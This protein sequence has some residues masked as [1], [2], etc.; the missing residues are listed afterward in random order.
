MSDWV[1]GIGVL[2]G[3]LLVALLV[4]PW[5]ST[6]LDRFGHPITWYVEYYKWVRRRFGP[7]R[8]R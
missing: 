2:V 4:F 6:L 8:R 3:A 5:A 7:G 1:I